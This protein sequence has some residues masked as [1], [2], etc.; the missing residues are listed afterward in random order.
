MIVSIVK[1]S[2]SFFMKTFNRIPVVYENKI[3]NPFHERL[4]IFVFKG[5]FQ[6]AYY[7]FCF[8]Y[9]LAYIKIKITA[10]QPLFTSFW[11]DQSNTSVREKIDKYKKSNEEEKKIN[12][13]TTNSSEILKNKKVYLMINEFQHTGKGIEHD[14][15]RVH[16][17]TSKQVGINLKQFYTD[18]FQFESNCKIIESDLKALNPDYL[19]M[20][21]YFF[22]LYEGAEKEERI[23]FISHM[24]DKFG[25]KLI[26]YSADPH[27]YGAEKETRYY[28]DIAD[29]I[30][31][32]SSWTPLNSFNEF[33]GKLS[34]MEYFTDDK[35]FFPKRKE[36]D[37]FFSGVHQPERAEILT[38]AAF[39]SNKLKLKAK[40]YVRSPV[41]KIR[42]LTTPIIVDDETYIDFIR[43]SRALIN[44]G[45]KGTLENGKPIH[46][47][48]GRIAEAI[49]SG[50][51]VI[52]YKPKD[53]TTFT[54]DS[55]YT[56][57]KEYLPFSSRKEL[58]DILCLLK[59]EPDTISEI[60]HNGRKK[61]LECYN[62]VK[63]WENIFIKQRIN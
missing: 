48:N 31:S 53:D 2:Y 51:A 11:L 7:I 26:I 18:N 21:D 37:V 47:I 22:T 34:R 17:N 1:K 19:I 6:K 57:W 56:P 14:I 30:I 12:F 29:K 20:F 4:Y 3:K 63:S 62:S 60:A 25:F 52:Q 23:S 40:F 44:T 8:K 43:K 13:H 38:F 15:A 5:D 41:K 50:T 49:V 16:V 45:M 28:Y 9:L 58:K 35:V 61:Y 24:K 55:Y 33:Q 54:L 36:N 42:D 46:V 59:Y 39:V 32:M 10:K 27:Y